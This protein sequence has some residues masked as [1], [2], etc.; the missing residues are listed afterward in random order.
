M[1]SQA[2]I[3]EAEAVMTPTLVMGNPGLYAWS[4]EWDETG[5]WGR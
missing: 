3:L 1:S 5:G 4:Y 2:R